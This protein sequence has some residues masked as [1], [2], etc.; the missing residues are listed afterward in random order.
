[1]ALKRKFDLVAW[2]YW[3]A[4]LRDREPFSLESFAQVERDALQLVRFQQYVFFSQFHALRAAARARNIS[5]MGDIPIYAAWDSADVWCARHLWRLD[6]RGFPALQAGVPPDYFSAT[7][8]LWGNPIYRWDAMEQEGFSWWIDRFRAT[9]Q[10]FDLVRVD[11]FRGFQAYWAVPG[12]DTTAV[13]GEWLPGPA[14]RLFAAIEAA[15]G[16]L[17]I[18]AE[19][20]GVITPEV[21][22]IRHR[23][24]FPGMAVLQFAFGNDPQAP[25]FRPHNYPRDVVAYSGTHDNDTTAGWWGSSGADSTRTPESILAEREYALR[26]LGLDA[27][28]EIHWHFIRAL[29]ASVANTVLFPAQDLLGL[30]SDARMNMPSTLGGNWLWRLQPGTLTSAL[31]QRLRALAELYDR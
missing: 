9:F 20:L 5:L 21:E 8:Q 4:P 26:Y 29:M 2:P 17:P 11:H 15:L 24:G 18:L 16:R 23:F 27:P 1:M 6:E 13:N 25:S 31:A 10:L 3:P 28:G 19:N 30:G 22:A 14:E 12:K 7:G